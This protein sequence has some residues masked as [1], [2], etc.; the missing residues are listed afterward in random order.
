[1]LV[2]GLIRIRLRI[3]NE[4][5]IKSGRVVKCVCSFRATADWV[6]VSGG[7]GGVEEKFIHIHLAAPWIS[8]S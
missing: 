5:T 8:S 7:E 3:T 2:V 6:E 1:M 4:I